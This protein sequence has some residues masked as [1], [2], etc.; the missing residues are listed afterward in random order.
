MVLVTPSHTPAVQRETVTSSH[1]SRLSISAF[2]SI[3]PDSLPLLSF[4]LISLALVIYLFS[5]R[6]QH[7]SHSLRLYYAAP[8]Q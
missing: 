1:P 7:P 4:P 8:P 6:C 3:N 2:D 5:V